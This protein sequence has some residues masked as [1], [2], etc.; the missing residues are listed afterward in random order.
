MNEKTGMNDMEK[1]PL[2]S[3]VAASLENTIHD[4]NRVKSLL[5]GI[6]RT[7]GGCGEE[8]DGMKH[9]IAILSHVQ[10]NVR[11]MLHYSKQC[12]EI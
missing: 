11:V 4:M 3:N 10:N 12:A 1:F 6:D 9:A 5:I 8:I 7:E 2:H